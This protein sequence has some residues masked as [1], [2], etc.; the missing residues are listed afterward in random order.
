MTAKESLLETAQIVLKNLPDDATLRD[1][2]DELEE[3]E[4]IEEGL[5]DERE[6]RVISLDEF[7]QRT[8]LCLLK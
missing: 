2:I 3:M 1:F 4:A 6:G 8:E 7:K 5:Q